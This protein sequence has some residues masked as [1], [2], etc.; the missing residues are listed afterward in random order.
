MITD[1]VSEAQRKCVCMHMC[2]IQKQM[3]MHMGHPLGVWLFQKGQT[4]VLHILGQG[5][6]GSE[7]S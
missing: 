5:E 6:E 7:K 4:V 1:Q 3:H 2:V